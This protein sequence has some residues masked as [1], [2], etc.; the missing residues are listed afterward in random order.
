M[1]RI[2]ARRSGIL[3]RL[4]SKGGDCICLKLVG[5]LDKAQLK[6]EYLLD[7]HLLAGIGL[8]AI[9]LILMLMFYPLTYLISLLS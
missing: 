8:I 6:D 5:S 1:C 7:I 4:D 9:L 3:H 2:S